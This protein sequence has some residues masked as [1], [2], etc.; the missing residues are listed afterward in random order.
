MASSSSGGGNP[1]SSWSQQ[2]SSNTQQGQAGATGSMSQDTGMSKPKI[3]CHVL[4]IQVQFLPHPRDA[5]RY[6][7]CVGVRF[8]TRRCPA[9]C[10]W[11]QKQAACVV[12]DGMEDEAS[13]T[14]TPAAW[15]PCSTAGGGGRT[16]WQ[17]P[18]P[19]DPSRFIICYDS[20]RYDVYRCS[21][22][23]VW[24]QDEQMC[25]MESTSPPT[26]VA[27]TT[28][29]ADESSGMTAVCRAGSSSTLSVYHAYPLDV[30]RFLQCDPAGHVFVLHCGPGKLWN[31]GYK[32]CVGSNGMTSDQGQG[33]AQGQA[34]GQGQGGTWMQNEMA[35]NQGLGNQWMWDTMTSAQQQSQGQSG[36]AQGQDGAA[37]TTEIFWILCPLR[38]QYDAQQGMCVTAGNNSGTSATSMCPR[39]FSWNV[40]LHVCIQRIMTSADV[41]GS[42][43]GE[44]WKDPSS[45]SSG[46]MKKPP[47]STVPTVSEKDNPCI[48]G[49]GFYFPFPNNSAFFIQCD[50]AGNAFVQPC[51]AGLEWNQLLLT[52]AGA[53]GG[54]QNA[55]S[56]GD[57][58]QMTGKV[59]DTA[60]NGQDS[61][62][63]PGGMLS[64]LGLSALVD[65]CSLSFNDG[66]VFPNP[67]NAAAFLQCSAGVAVVRPCPSS[68]V[69]NQRRFSC[70][71]EASSP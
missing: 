16:R 27:T 65:P 68:T 8:V 56:A 54:G 19:G 10:V 52:C 3:L 37:T 67:V 53:A 1:S 32:T 48:P 60:S 58:G 12:I 66:A 64:Q 7:E 20:T 26:T 14:T 55:S 33:Q 41:S 45:S 2:M 9:N 22:G 36:Q 4:N 63:K 17:L 47:M 31:D 42:S 21:A 43:S 11:D 70:V 39:G 25:G 59:N 28:A 51:P 15:N 5:S 40:V 35:T 69:W 50:L 49:A 46:Q 6:Y 62:G 29:A 24:M 30:S 34:Q 23:L 44:K 13:A 18:Y 38:Y 71:S 57:D 61:A